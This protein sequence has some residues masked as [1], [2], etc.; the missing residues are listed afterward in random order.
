MAV[1]SD[2]NSQQLCRLSLTLDPHDQTLDE[3]YAC[4]VAYMVGDKSNSM[5]Y[6]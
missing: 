4:Q 1:E 3:Q 2:L 6:I 5:L